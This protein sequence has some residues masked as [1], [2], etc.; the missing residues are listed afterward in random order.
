METSERRTRR[1]FLRDTASIGAAGVLTAASLS[2]GTSPSERIRLGCIGVGKRGSTVLGE[3]L[4]EKN[5]KKDVDIVA[6]SDVWTER[7]EA[8]MKRCT[9]KPVGIVDYRELLDRKD[10]DGVVI[11][12]P[13]HWHALQV[14]HA[15]EA[16]KDVYVEKPMT[17]SVQESF[18]VD[19]AAKEHKRVT[20][21]GTQIHALP[22]Y[23]R[24]VEIVRSGNLGKVTLARCFMVMNQ[25]PEGIGRADDC[26]PPAGLDWDLWCGPARKLPFNPRIVRSAYDNC[27][28]M[29]YSGGWT[30]GMAP[31][32]LDLPY[33]ALDLGYPRRVASFGSRRIVQDGGDCPDCQE[34]LWE[35]DDDFT[36]AWTLSIANS[37]GFDF[38]GK[39]E[40]R[41]RH[42]TYFRGPNGTLMSDYTTH[43]IVPEG[44]R[45]ENAAPVEKT[46]PD[47]VGH[48]REWLDAIRTRGEPLCHV[49]YHHRIDVAISLANLSCKLA[50]SL[51]FDAEKKEIVGDA[52]ATRLLAR[53]YRAPWE[54]PKRYV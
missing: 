42:G 31:H 53:E 38:Q 8:A 41:R 1:R 11:A 4:K 51:E 54:L 28:F 36:L 21:V 39:N 27:S 30:P 10:I 48:Y 46:I 25:G 20:Q 23:R 34:A 18:A 33:W 45:M 29:E 35:Y 5:K 49:G 9:D 6:I 26:K 37:F 22:N 2:A 50:R 7:R 43:R 47:S 15:C 19:K 24:A 17:L 52:E 14:I 16:G 13:P 44:K 32:I 12:T 3:F 40:T